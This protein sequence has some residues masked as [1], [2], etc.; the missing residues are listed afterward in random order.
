MGAVID[1]SGLFG[2]DQIPLTW[3]RVLGILLLAVGAGLSLYR[4]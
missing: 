4:G 3:P 1:R 2:L